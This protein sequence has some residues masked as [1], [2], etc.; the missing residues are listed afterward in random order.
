MRKHLTAIGNSL[1]IVIEKPILE[2]LNID[3][4]TELELHTDGTRLII[5]PARE[6]RRKRVAAAT[7]RVMKAHDATLRRLAK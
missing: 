7:A 6:G 5:E 2:L 3:R 4:E 1:G